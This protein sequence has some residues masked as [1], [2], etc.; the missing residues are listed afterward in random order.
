MSGID[1]VQDRFATHEVTNQPPALPAYNAWRGDRPLREAVARE[2]GDWAAG[3]LETYGALSGGDLMDAGRLANEHRP[4]L[5]LFDAYG[6]RIDE[7]EFHP[8]YHQ[9]M[10][11]AIAHGVHAFAWRHADRPGAHVARAALMYLDG[12]PDA[13]TSCPLTMTYAAVPALRYAP[14]LAEFWVTR[15]SGLQYDPRSVPADQ[16]TTCTMGMGMTEKQGGSDVRANTTVA[17]VQADGSYR[18]VGHKWFFSAP[19]CD[20]HLVLAQA[21]GGLSC[22]LTPRFRPDGERN[23]VRIQRLKDKLGDWSN[24]SAEVEFQEAWAARVGEAGR[25][26]ATILEMVALTR[27]DCMIGSAAT[28]RQALVQALHHTAHRSAFGRRLIEQPLMRNVLADL[29]LE[30]EAAVALAMRV[31]RAVDAAG[32]D[33]RE[34]ALARIATAMGK[35]WIC[36]RTPAHVNE[37][38]EC[39]GG[40]G[41][42][43]DTMLPRLY[44]QAPLNSI[45]EGSGNV[46]CL[47]VLRAL[48]KAPECR[49]AL[50]G[51]LAR[52]KGGHPAFDRA[53]TELSRALDVPAA[54][55][56]HSRY[57]VERA[58]LALQA[59][60]LIAGGRTEVAEIF[61]RSRLRDDHG[62]AFG[63]LPPDAPFDMLID[64]AGFAG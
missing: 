58:A 5:K 15:L 44:R 16:K 60:V 47:D 38:Q 59:A 36:R 4:R 14:E 52:A 34:A 25:G 17:T 18:L 3:R 57:L 27:L 30:S 35:Y 63:T 40:I 6:R 55:E 49:D 43:E 26:V 46:Q 31:A 39:L 10:G 22:F 1:P 13:G 2:G 12:Q 32:R 61:C 29:A 42:V 45:W 64:R 19:M 62:M 7:V 20:A 51:E 54:L 23:A 9:L 37:A 8:A 53:V 50:F 28:M 24:A 41:Y 48:A 21:D 56:V 33:P 11:T